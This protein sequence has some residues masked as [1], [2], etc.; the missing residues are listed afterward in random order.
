MKM[1][2]NKEEKMH[3]IFLLIFATVIVVLT[4]QLCLKKGVTEIGVIQVGSLSTLFQFIIKLLGNPLI[5]IGV[6]FSGVGAFIWLMV[7]SRVDLSLAFPISGGIF[8][9]LLFLVSRLILKEEIT[10]YRW[11]GL[12]TILIGITLMTKK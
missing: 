1:L 4:G 7:L 5:L 2:M 8:Y 10:L 12:I 11:M 9:M 6:F 3:K